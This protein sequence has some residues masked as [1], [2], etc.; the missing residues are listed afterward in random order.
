ME[1]SRRQALAGAAALALAGTLPRPLAALRLD[2]ARPRTVRPR[3]RLQ[4]GDTV[5]LVDPASAIWELMNVEVVVES[6]AALGFK[7]KPGANL[8][9]ARRGY[10]AG[11][12]EQRDTGSFRC[13]AK[14]LLVFLSRGKSP[15]CTCRQFQHSASVRRHFE[16]HPFLA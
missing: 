9:L 7:T 3:R 11:T 6:L 5:G 10:F 16:E 13:Y 12:D 1:T 15:M 4:P 14:D 8:L 2:G